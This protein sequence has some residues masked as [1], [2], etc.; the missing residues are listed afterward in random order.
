[1]PD[2]PE[3]QLKDWLAL[4][5]AKGIG[6]T[7]FKALLEYFQTP[8][9]VFACSRKQLEDLH[10]KEQCIRSILKPDWQGVDQDLEWLQAEQHHILTLADKRY[11][12]LLKEC[13]DA[14]AILFVTG[15]VEALSAPQIAMVGSRNPSPTGR[16]TAIEFARHLSAAGLCVT[17]GLAIG[18]DSACHQ[19][20]LDAEAATIA[21]TGTG[22]DR[23]YPARNRELAYAILEKGALVSE[24]PLNTP[25]RPENFPR[26]NRIIS[27]LSLGTVVVEAAIKSG[28][29]ITARYAIEQAREVFAIP[30]SIH[31]P[32]A[33]GNHLLIKQGAKLVETADD[34][35]SELGS[36]AQ[37]QQNLGQV[38]NN[39][40][41]K[42]RSHDPE[43]EQLLEKMGYDP[44]AVDEIV[45]RSGLTA[46]EVSSMMLILEL[47]GNVASSPGGCYVRV[48]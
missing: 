7:T 4:Y 34:I 32:L 22:L 40:E 9:A 3:A 48:K 17:S 18:I 24:F 30:G 29:L 42:Q 15:N 20:A 14:P 1:M 44:V 31:N 21:V 41:E 27:G 45:I 39:A 2:T 46:E 10:L 36:L 38:T 6:N 35:I 11:P 28:S 33:R 47:Q 12:P 5:R 26:R 37:A 13:D 8:S 16:Q 19:G 25:A 43:Y 23:I